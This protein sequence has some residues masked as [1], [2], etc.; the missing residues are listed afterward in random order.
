MIFSKRYVDQNG[1]PKEGLTIVPDRRYGYL[2]QQAKVASARVA[3]FS[4]GSFELLQPA[5]HL[6]LVEG[7]GGSGGPDSVWCGDFLRRFKLFFD[8]VGQRISSTKTSR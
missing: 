6:S 7:F 1:L 3:R 8:Y 2:G 5:V 4:V